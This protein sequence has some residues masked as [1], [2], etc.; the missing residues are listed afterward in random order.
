MQGRS[1]SFATRTVAVAASF[2]LP[3]AALAQ[4]A[5]QL[6][7][8]FGGCMAP[9]TTSKI[10]IAVGDMGIFAVAAFLFVRLMERRYINQDK[11]PLLG[12]HLGMSM[13]LFISVLGMFG[14]YYLVTGCITGSMW[15]WVGFAAFVFVVHAAYTL[16][17]VRTE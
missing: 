3:A 17:V 14:L 16:V 5:V 7:A 8:G 13:A 12:R 9:N 6:T 15:W 4:P 10:L 2:A 11:N 1:L